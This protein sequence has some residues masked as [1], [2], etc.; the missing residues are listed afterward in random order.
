M[1][2]HM[3][4]SLARTWVEQV[5]Q[6]DSPTLPAPLRAGVL[7]CGAEA[8]A[9]LLDALAEP[10]VVDGHAGAHVV[11]LLAD[12]AYAD[13][14]QALVDLVWEEPFWDAPAEAV[15]RFGTAA[16]PALLAVVEANPSRV[17]SVLA[18]CA[19]GSRHPQVRELL[20]TYLSED[21]AMAAPCVAD[22][23]DPAMLPHLLRCLEATTPEY[24]PSP[25]ARRPI[26]A[27][28]EAIEA[29]G[30]QAGALGH[31]KLRDAYA[32]RLAEQSEGELITA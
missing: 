12:L 31:A 16:V 5:L 14:I 21:P 11:Q 30:G 17:I 8:G 6:W 22:F 24:N 4:G 27:L 9:L 28:L 23:G 32:T 10:S 13:A 20:A 18:R 25:Y 7:S 2:V 26:L 19:A 15:V 29:L 3:N 1:G